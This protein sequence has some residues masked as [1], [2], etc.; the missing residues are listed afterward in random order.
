MVL[1]N[2]A[3]LVGNVRITIEDKSPALTFIIFFN[4]PGILELK[5]VVGEYDPESLHENTPSKLFVQI[6]KN[7]FNRL[8][9][10]GWKEENEHETAPAEEERKQ[11]FT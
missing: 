1:F 4:R 10:A 6:V 3:L 7:V 8:L 5:P 2:P 11:A 9:G